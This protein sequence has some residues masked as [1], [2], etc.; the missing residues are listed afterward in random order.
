MKHQRICTSCG[1]SK[2]TESFY[3]TKRTSNEG[4]SYWCKQCFK[5]F[6]KDPSTRDKSAVLE[7]KDLKAKEL[8]L[9]LKEGKSCHRCGIHKDAALFVSLGGICKVC[10]NKSGRRAYTERVRVVG[11]ADWYKN[12]FVHKATDA[13][14]RGIPFS[15]SFE[16]FKELVDTRFCFYCECDM[17][18]KTRKSYTSRSID[19][20][21]NSK[22][23]TD[24]NTVA[25][26]R[27]CNSTK[28]I[29]DAESERAKKIWL[30]IKDLT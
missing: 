23:Y 2:D 19:R 25:C 1:Q 9:F 16:R 7:R 26:C 5:D 4:F 18:N 20:V 13:K 6:S 29:F 28:N 21:M 22:G 12:K 17:S 3:R 27:A 15:V 24:A 8:A 14:S 10:K 30:K 11:S